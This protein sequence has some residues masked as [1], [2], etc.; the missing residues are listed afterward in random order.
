M[1]FIE[2]TFRQGEKKVG[3]SKSNAFSPE[4]AANLMKIVGTAACYNHTSHKQHKYLTH[5][6]EGFPR[7][8]MLD[9]MEAGVIRSQFSKS[10]ETISEQLKKLRNK[11]TKT[12]TKKSASKNKQNN[13]KSTK[14]NNNIITNNIND[15]NNKLKNN[16]KTINNNNN[17]TKSKKRKIRPPSDESSSDSESESLGEQEQYEECGDEVE[18]GQV[19]EEEDEGGWE[20][21]ICEGIHSYYDGIQCDDCK[22]WY[23][24]VCVSVSSEPQED[25]EAYVCYRC[26][27]E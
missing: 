23:H 7:F 6:Q 18:A 1:E 16:N 5:T 10:W 20:E 25:E 4:T 22:R 8:S 14:Q 12:T 11:V 9:R 13:A 26:Q 2:F 3:G 15:N 27:E 21:C 19:E 17:T 24:C